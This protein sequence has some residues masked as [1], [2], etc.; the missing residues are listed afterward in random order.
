[1]RAGP[2]LATAL[3][4]T[5]LLTACSDDGPPVRSAAPSRTP[6]PTTAA[7]QEPGTPFR[8]DTEPDVEQVTGGPFVLTA[9]RTARQE[10]FDRV[11]VDLTGSGT[12]GWDARYV[13]EARADGSGEA[14]PVAGDSV[15]QVA[16]RGLDTASVS[17]RVAGGGEVVREVAFL[18]VFEA[19]ALVVI[20]LAGP[21][22]PFRVYTLADPLRLVVDVRDR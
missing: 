5:G 6:A 9:V 2:L 16:V 10:G 15:L 14:V 7:T 8:A 3:L 19:Q 1:M 22:R 21:Q 20:G 18:P 17:G 4:V 11:V 12:P 13:D